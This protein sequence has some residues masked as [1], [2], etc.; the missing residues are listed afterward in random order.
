[1][2]K[3]YT[4]K[5]TAQTQAT[6]QGRKAGVVLEAVQVDGG[7]QIG[8]V[9]PMPMPMPMPASKPASRE[10]AAVTVGKTA[11]TVTLSLPVTTVSGTYVGARHQGREIWFDRKSLLSLAIAGGVAT[12]E[13]ARANAVRRRL[14]QPAA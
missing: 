2:S 7:W 8:P 6:K 5:S 12:L 3:I 13:L 9:M 11:R 4:S 1:M 10:L 14:V